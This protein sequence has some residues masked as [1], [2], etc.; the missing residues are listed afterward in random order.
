MGGWRAWSWTGPQAVQHGIGE[1]ADQG[2]VERTVPEEQPHVEGA[3]ERIACRIAIDPGRT[4][5]RRLGLAPI[6]G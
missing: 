6:S 3:V 4:G 2:V 1:L 5:T